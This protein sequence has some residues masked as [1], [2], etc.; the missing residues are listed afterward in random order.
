MKKVSSGIWQSITIWSQ[1]G[2][3]IVIRA[4]TQKALWNIILVTA[5]GPSPLEAKNSN[6]FL[7]AFKPVGGFLR[8]SFIIYVHNT[9]V[10]LPEQRL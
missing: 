3:K 7:F 6:E 2:P 9:G 8:T 10:L 5:E 4:P 1:V